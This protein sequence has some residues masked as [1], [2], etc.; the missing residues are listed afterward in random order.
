[1]NASA[2]AAVAAEHYLVTRRIWPPY[3]I[4]SAIESGKRNVS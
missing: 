2:L 4:F 3:A 1:M